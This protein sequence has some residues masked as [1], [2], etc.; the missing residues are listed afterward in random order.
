VSAISVLAIAAVEAL[1]RLTGPVDRSTLLT[2]FLSALSAA[3]IVVGALR[4]RGPIDEPVAGEHTFGWSLIA[5]GA[6]D[7]LLATSLQSGLEWA[8]LGA[9]VQ[10]IGAAGVTRAAVACFIDVLEHEGGHKM[11]LAGELTDVTMVL[12][13]EQSVRRTLQHDARNVVTA[14]RAAT[15]TLQRHRDRISP[16]MQEQLQDTIGSEFGRLQAMLDAPVDSASSW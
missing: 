6:G 14:I 9:A 12:A 2:T 1:I 11:R 3:W 5:F 16:E 13:D 7:A 8:V 15:S 4:V 10:L